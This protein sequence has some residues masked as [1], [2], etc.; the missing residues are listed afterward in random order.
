M[1]CQGNV[2]PEFTLEMPLVLASIDRDISL[3]VELSM[4]ITYAGSSSIERE[5]TILPIVK[6]CA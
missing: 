3:F 2:S 5:T 1:E 4:Y 6:I